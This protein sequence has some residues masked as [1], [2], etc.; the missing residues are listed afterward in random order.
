MT[1]THDHN[2]NN[3]SA[4][5]T[6]FNSINVE[7]RKSDTALTTIC[8]RI[9][10]QVLHGYE[11]QVAIK[12][13][14]GTQIFG[15]SDAECFLVFH[16]PGVIREL[17]LYRSL[18]RLIEAYL[19]GTVEV[20]GNLEKLF[21]LQ[22]HL[23][24]LDLSWKA[25]WYLLRL[26][27]SL[28]AHQH[29]MIAEKKSLL[30]TTRKNS[31][32]SIAHHYD[33][34]NE[35]YRLWL[36]PEMVYSCAYFRNKQQSLASAQHD[37]L[38]YLCRKL[39][40]QPGQTLLDI[41]CGWGA[42][43]IHAAYHYGVSVH[44][45]TLSEEQRR[46]AHQRVSDEGLEAQVKITLCDYRDLPEQIVYDRV[47]SVGM[48]EHVGVKNFPAYFGTVKRILKP[49]GLFL[50]HGIT[51]ETGWQ[52]TPMT[53]FINRYIFPDGELTRVSKVANCMEQAGFEIL[54]I[55]SLRRHYSY[56]LRHWVSALESS[57]EKA[58]QQTSE[59][60]FRLW[61]LYMAGSA[62]Y[63]NE[64]SLNVYQLLVGHRH[65]PLTIPLRRDDLYLRHEA[66]NI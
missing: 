19:D 39:R 44:G 45:I 16:D 41:G 55:E 28:P 27:L 65:G 11:G 64:G 59:A 60:T 49:G 43:A 56:T 61:R 38:D 5:M 33:V 21:E 3:G 7:S 40:L 15:Q 2:T 6:G 10:S 36:D 63:F 4:K 31:R 34:G 53:H 46:F 62:H 18:S 23:K 22:N 32:A 66:T 35:F 30:H 48:F 13:G 14:N 1:Q 29:K 42:L 17:V 51:N 52:R 37:K 24:T 50:N 8:T 25:Q 9:V 57:R 26:A 20:T 47:V 58:I 12:L 54:D